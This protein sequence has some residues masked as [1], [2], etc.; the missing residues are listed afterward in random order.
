VTDRRW[1]DATQT[2]ALRAALDPVEEATGAWVELMARVDLA[3]LWDAEVYR[4]LPMV[5]RNLGPAVGADNENRLR[6]LYRQGWVHNQHLLRR[7]AE[8]VTALDGAGIDSLLLKGVPL[9]IGY[10]GD[11]GVRPMG[12]ADVLVRPEQAVAAFRLLEDL[13]Y[14]SMSIRSPE[15][16]R[17]EREG[18]DDWHLRLR[19][20]RGYERG[21]MDAV[22]L[23]WALSLDF[24][25]ADPAV[26]GVDD[27]FRDARPITVEGV[28]AA[29][30]SPTHH[31]L[32]AVV[33]GLG[34]SARAELRWIPDALTILAARSDASGES[35]GGVDGD[36]LVVAALRHHCDLMVAEGLVHLADEWD[37]TVPPDAIA[38]LAGSPAD[39][40]QRALRWIRRHAG[41]RPLGSGYAAGLFVTSTA[42]R[43]PV[44]T[45]A[46]GP[47]FLADHWHLARLAHLPLAVGHRLRPH[48]APP[49]E[50]A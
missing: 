34:A 23:H 46:R 15:A 5:W 18:D 24:V 38:R 47:G 8:V 43:G 44:A 11:A 27:F 41:A 14:R 17:W 21:P 48:S 30:L 29:T 16:S 10:Y 35:A 3:E 36:E 42:G 31:L 20:A 13:G 6:G 12:D 49:G 39:T 25:C 7:A 33:H 37:A 45:A 28:S 2:L 32:H 50:P 19:H 22:D 1:P 40:R 9:T 4:L 26:A